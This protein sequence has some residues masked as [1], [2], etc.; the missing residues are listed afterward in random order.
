MKKKQSS[1]KTIEKLIVEKITIDEQNS[2]N[3]LSLKLRGIT[4]SNF[5]L[6]TKKE[7]KTIMLNEKFG[8]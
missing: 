3:S 7:I 4:K 1:A 6:M 2:L 8:I 5:S